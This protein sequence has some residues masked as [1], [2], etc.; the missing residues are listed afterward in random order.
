ML[1][2]GTFPCGDGGGG[3]VAF[4]DIFLWDP[5]PLGLLSRRRIFHAFLGP[6]RGNSGDPE[7]VAHPSAP[8][9]AAKNPIKKKNLFSKQGIFYAF[10][11]KTLGF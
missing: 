1:A 5:R 2:S 6:I 4:W 8:K 9:H 3:H 11:L 10:F 7:R